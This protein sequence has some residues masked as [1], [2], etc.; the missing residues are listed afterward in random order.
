[1]PRGLANSHEHDPRNF[2]LAEW[3]Q[4]KRTGQ[5][6][7]AIKT[8]FQDAWAISDSKA[9]FINAQEN[10]GFKPARGD[11][12]GFV[13]VDYRGEIYAI[14]KWAGVRTKQVQNRLGDKHELPSLE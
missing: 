13:A 11:R 7:Q 12:R 9:A 2:T 14:A 1:M 8:A 10:R 5:N 6:P 3:Q 4:A